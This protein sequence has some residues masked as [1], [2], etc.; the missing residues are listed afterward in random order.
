MSVDKAVA[1]WRDILGD[2]AVS[3]DATAP[4]LRPRTTSVSPHRQLV[5]V[6][7][8]STAEQ[9]IEVVRVARE[10]RVPLYPV[11][12]GR[13]WGLGSRL[14]V[15]PGGALLDLSGL[16]RIR[17]VDE[18]GRYAIVEPGVSQ[19]QLA[20]HLRRHAPGLVPN[21]TG[22]TPNSSILGN[23]LERGTGFRRH[24]AEEVRGLEVVL[25]TGEL[26][27]TGLWAGE[28]D[29]Q[30]HHYRHGLGPGLDQLFV[31]SGLGVV[32]AAVVDLVPVREEL[33]LL[34]FSLSE[35]AL[36]QVID[37][38]GELFTG[39][40]LRSIVHIF[41]NKRIGSMSDSDEVPLWTG[42]VAVDGVAE[43][44]AAVVPLVAE[45]LTGAGAQ[46]RVVDAEEAAADHDPL[47]SAM[48]DVHAGRPS[49]AFLEGLHRAM[50]HEPPA[51][52]DALDETDI[53]YLACMP[54]VAVDGAA[55]TALIA[56][57]EAV[58]GRHGVAPA[59][60]VN[61][62]GADY[63]EVVINLYFDRT[64]EAQTA[65]A[66]ACNAELHERLYAD[67]FRFYRV[68]ID[69]MDFVTHQDTAPWGAI[70]LIKQALD[71]DGVIAP[72]RYH[73]IDA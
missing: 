3:A 50:G 68:G 31:Q 57:V 21:V 69:A 55:V 42:V 19:A 11:S 29:R 5:A 2:T 32:T 8:P 37:T 33:R 70:G 61:P 30:L 43:Q 73:R 23:L 46:V 1:A 41:N 71:P 12:T 54:V 67:G 10:Q 7:R 18:R 34:M 38:V 22:S 16:A 17:A 44:V 51:D 27:R 58:C 40:V 52:L 35:P 66:H 9:V 72:G 25:G 15:R 56:R 64:D 6:L 47:I 14:P 39:D 62:T 28:G 59:L 13:N 45:R 36:P 26:I 65:A 63:A 20:D 48:F 4:E 24:R 49:T 60:A 53:G